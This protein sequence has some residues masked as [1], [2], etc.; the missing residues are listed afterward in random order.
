MQSLLY[1]LGYFIFSEAGT[2]TNPKVIWSMSYQMHLI[3]Q[4]AK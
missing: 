3:I 4:K 1:I 2:S